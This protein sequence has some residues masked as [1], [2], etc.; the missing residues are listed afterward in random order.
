MNDITI[1]TISRQEITNND[2]TRFDQTVG[3]WAE[4]RGQ[5]LSNRHNS[6]ILIIDGFN[7]IQ[8]EL[9]T[10]PEVREYMRGLHRRWPWLL[11]FL[12]IE[13]MGEHLAI[14]YLCLVDTVNSVHRDGSAD[15]CAVFNPD[16][17]L[18]LLR[19][20]FCRMNLLFERA[21][22]SDSNNDKRTD[23]ILALLFHRKE[24]PNG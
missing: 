5:E 17:M 19:R 8:D 13:P 23:E 24:V 22:L 14:A 16:Q 21:S 3:P 11:F 6:L 2:Y 9:Y 7:E 10:I 18:D 4:L 12:N 20:D 15:T 1:Y